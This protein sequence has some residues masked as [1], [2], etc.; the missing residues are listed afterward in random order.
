MIIIRIGLASDR[1]LAGSGGTANDSL[2]PP[3][4]TRTERGP[5][6]SAAH[7][8][9]HLGWLHDRGSHEMKSLAVEITEYRETYEDTLP[10]SVDLEE[11]KDRRKGKG[12]GLSKENLTIV[13]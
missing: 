4:P 5:R 10:S 13:V 2:P 12:L 8:P 11:M 3:S 6:M 1:I 7:A 9:F